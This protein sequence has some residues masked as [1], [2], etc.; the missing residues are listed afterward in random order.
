MQFRKISLKDKAIF[1]RFL[2]CRMP[3]LSAYAFENIFIWQSLYDIFWA[4]INKSLCVFF[5][6]RVG[7]F[8]YLSPLGKANGEDTVEKCFEI[9]DGFN[10][11]PVVSRIE[12]A[13]ERDLDFYKGLGY[14]TV[15]A[16]CDYVCKKEALADLK[17]E[18]FKKKRAL[19]N[20]FVNKY[21]FQYLI[22]KPGDKKEC[23]RLY[24]SW[25]KERKSQNSDRIY[26]G[27]LDDNFAVFK[28]MLECFGK[29]NFTGR[30]VKIGGRI[31]AF[32]FG[33]ELNS[34]SFVILFEVCDLK[35]KGIA[36]YIFREFS[37]ELDYK[38]I[39]IMDDSG[40]ASLKKVKL[41]YRPYRTLNCFS[42]NRG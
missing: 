33:Y 41:S 39:N 18:A 15:L 38:D 36:Q 30:V 7:C 37:R 40:L 22:Y 26:Q 23:I 21:N 11:N 10:N 16:G 20:N 25:M 27:L 34:D 13:E 17:G 2:S 14:K 31:R 42:V 9:M 8:L 3:Q 19:A 5:K 6:D 32:T 28:A 12:N 1:D 35:L 4:K 24:L 29:L